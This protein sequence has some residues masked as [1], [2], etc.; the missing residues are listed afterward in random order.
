MRATMRITMRV[1][2]EPS[3][4]FFRGPGPPTF[5]RR[6]KDGPSFNERSCRSSD[7]GAR[8]AERRTAQKIVFLS[9]L[10]QQAQKFVPLLHREGSHRPFLRL[11]DSTLRGRS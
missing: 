8:R 2:R 3:E 10:A 11:G 5:P 9:E 6:T 1:S 4:E 7:G